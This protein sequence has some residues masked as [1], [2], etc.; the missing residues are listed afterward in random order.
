[1]DMRQSSRLPFNS[2]NKRLNSSEYLTIDNVT[3]QRLEFQPKHSGN[4]VWM[5]RVHV[6]DR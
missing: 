2:P 5:I 4:D 1:M 6:P 3:H